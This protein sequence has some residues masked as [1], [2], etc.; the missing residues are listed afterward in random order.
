MPR[1][2]FEFHCEGS[3]RG[4]TL[5]PLDVEEERDIIL[6]CPNC[7]HEHYRTL[8]NGEI[9]QIRHNQRTDTD[10][11]HRIEPVMSAFSKTSRL[12][13]LEKRG[14]LGDLWSR[15]AGRN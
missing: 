9:T 15:F 1:D 14:P 13:H 12:Q 10:T 2:L 11:V 3:C 7:K 4:Y 6:V 8:R 5:V